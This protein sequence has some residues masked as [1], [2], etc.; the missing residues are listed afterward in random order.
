MPDLSSYPPL[1]LTY[2]SIYQSLTDMREF[3]H[4]TGRFDDS[5]AK[6]D[7]VVKFIAMYL[8]YQRGLIN[9][10]PNPNETNRNLV[11]E[12]R[13][14]FSK[15]IKLGWCLNQDGTSI[16]GPNPALSLLDED[17]ALAK[18]LVSLVCKAVDAALVNREL[19][20]PFDVL[21]E[22]FGH[23]VRDNFRSNI[24]DAQY[25]TPPEVVD[26]M[27]S[28]ALEDIEREL[29]PNLPRE[30]L[31]V[32]DSTCGVGSFLTA[33]YHKSQTYK[34]TQNRRIRL[35]GQDKVERMIRLTKIN[36]ALFNAAEYK[37]T[38]G[39]SLSEYSP[40]STLN[41]TA[42]LVLTNPPFGAKFD[43]FEIAAFGEKNLPIFASVCRRLQSVNSEL[44]FVDRNLSLLADSGRLLIIVPDSVV[45]AKGLPALLRQQLRA[46]AIVRAVIELPSVTFA[47]AG[48]RTKTCILYLVKGKNAA[49][50]V[51]VAKAND[52][53]FEVSS[54]K[55]IQVKV[56]RGSNDLAI[57]FNA[58]KSFVQE[59]NSNTNI[60]TEEPSCVSVN[61]ED[62]INDS[63]TPNRH[64]ASRLR[65]ITR[66]EHLPDIE[67]IPLSS[68]VDFQS[69]GRPTKPWS[70]NNY[71]I[72]VLHVIGEGMLDMHGI[73]C[74]RPKTPGLE[75]KPDEILFSRINP[76]IPRAFVMPNLGRKVLC[77]SEFEIMS[78][79]AGIDPYLIAFLL[80]SDSVHN[81]IKSLTSG[82]SASHN[83]I[84][85]D[86][87]AKILLPIPKAGTEYED[88]IKALIREYRK[89]IEIL[90]KQTIV[91]SE[92][93]DKEKRQNI[94]NSH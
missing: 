72:S 55:G 83:R 24:E 51:F 25:M 87:L 59:S 8:S 93:R 63:W 53:G 77:S 39:N 12:L 49:K 46:R 80:L 56:P 90:V 33:F 79:K 5:N 70:K 7:E 76:R 61:Y 26:I 6:L 45:S 17:K 21:N 71:F 4:R 41:G 86:D 27:V 10:F 42:D 18:A 2:S 30:Q 29:A 47:Q 58:Y 69:A 19:D 57:I 34:V 15:T 20:R 67:A 92:I 23:F 50:T 94:N 81:Q 1:T 85:T 32:L 62:F 64:N 82:T 3:F 44:L 38:I 35:V 89:T 13:A 9:E 40:L 78:I 11:G 66:L 84:K 54:R 31:T 37:V 75:V 60:I 91:L 74:Y 68:L 73:K 88:E 52:L 22:A 14:I 43:R 16:F 65:A 36:L 28:I 48:T